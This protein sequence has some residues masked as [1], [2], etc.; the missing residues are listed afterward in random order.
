MSRTILVTG[1]TGYIARHII[2]QLLNRGDMVIG[3]AR[4]VDRE[5]ELRD[6]IAP[7]V[8]DPAALERFRLVP[9]SLT[10]D[11][12]WADAMAGVDA[13]MH[14]ASP[15]PLRQPK[16]AQE[17]IRPAVDG[18]LHAMRAAQAAGVQNVVLT[19]STVA[20]TNGALKPVYDEAD[21]SPKDAGQSAYARSKVMAEPAPAPA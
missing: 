3:S 18:A 2:A 15:F 1:A 9:L 19:S 14:T 13:V 10:S 12:G 20:I 11:D 17:V 4:T 6:A 5:M 16:D 8:D 21:W 7:T